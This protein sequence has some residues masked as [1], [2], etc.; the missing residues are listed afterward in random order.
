M[1]VYSRNL[2]LYQILFFDVN[3]GEKKTP[4][5]VMNADMIHDTCR[6]K[7][8][9]T[10]FN[11]YGLCISYHELLRYHNDLPSY[12]LSQ[13][14]EDVPL[15]SHFHTNI[16]TTAAFDNF[17]HNERTR[18]GLGSS[19]DTVSI[20]IQDKPDTIY[21]K[22]NISEIPVRHGCKTFIGPLPCQKLQ[23]FY[24]CSKKIEIPDDFNPSLELFTINIVDYDDIS[25]TDVAWELS[26]LDHSHKI[27]GIL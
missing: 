10:G 1:Y 23:E 20:L 22:P 8:L 17:G 24:K 3:N 5:H 19:H 11:H 27:R 7:T 4:L 21:R 18:A 25:K 15:P 12:I 16:H 26:R 14:S 6:S 2:V 13:N 9:I